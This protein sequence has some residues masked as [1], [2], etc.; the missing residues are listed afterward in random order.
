M[1]ISTDGFCFLIPQHAYFFPC[2][3]YSCCRLGLCQASPRVFI[4]YG[5]RNVIFV[6]GGS[7]DGIGYGYTRKGYQGKKVLVM[8][9]REIVSLVKV[10]L[11]E[12]RFYTAF[13][14]R[15]LWME[16]VL[17]DICGG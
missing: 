2:F 15:G 14:R 13:G 4:A 9:L 8:F 3:A 16:V 11:A 12:C 7:T 5:S 10:M 6:R 17:L 1:S